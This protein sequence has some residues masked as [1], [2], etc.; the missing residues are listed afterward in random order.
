MKTVRTKF[1]IPDTEE[2]P[3]PEASS[4]ES[5][6]KEEQHPIIRP[7]ASKLFHEAHNELE[8]FRTDQ[9]NQLGKRINKKQ[10]SFL[11]LLDGSVDD[12]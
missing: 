9:F 5:D 11:K 7:Q 1:H 3:G 12:T 2:S 10:Q 8:K 4:T 6:N